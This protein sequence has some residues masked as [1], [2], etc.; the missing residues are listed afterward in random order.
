MMVKACFTSLIIVVFALF[1]AVPLAR[2]A[3]DDREYRSKE[4]LEWTLFLLFVLF[5]L[6]TIGA[7]VFGILAIWM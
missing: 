2:M 7:V 3:N 5:A 1:W 6:G 4:W